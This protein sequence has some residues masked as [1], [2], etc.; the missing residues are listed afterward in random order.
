MAR[1]YKYP[2]PEAG[3]PF[4]LKINGFCEVA[5]VGLDG[6][7][8]PCLWAIVTPEKPEETWTY[9]VLATGEEFDTTEWCF[10]RSFQQSSSLG[11]LTWHL[12][13]PV[14]QWKQ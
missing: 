8:T 11:L 5:H 13:R 1:I 4:D 14:G 6:N 2:M 7:G 9:L 10:I 12:F 3:K